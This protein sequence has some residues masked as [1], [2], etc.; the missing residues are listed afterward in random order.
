MSRSRLVKGEQ[1]MENKRDITPIEEFFP[2]REAEIAAARKVIERGL[3]GYALLEDEAPCLDKTFPQLMTIGPSLK[4]LHGWF[5]SVPRDE[6]SQ[7]T[8]CGNR[9]VRLYN[10]VPVRT[11]SRF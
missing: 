1:A 6:S 10:V 2:S 5:G 7:D 11:D 4:D 3:D 8:P 9:L